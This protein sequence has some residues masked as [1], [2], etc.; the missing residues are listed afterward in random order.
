[1][2]SN[3]YLSLFPALLIC[4]AAPTVVLAQG[5]AAGVSPGRFELSAKPG[6][7]IRET[8]A[9]SNP[10]QT[11]A[12]Y[13]LK[14]AD[15]Q[16][17]DASSVEYIEDS[18]TEGSCRPWVRLERKTVAVA[19][20]GRKNYRFEV[21][22]PEDAAP[23]LCRFA[24]L[25]EPAEAYYAKVGDGSVSIPVVGRYAVIT[26]VTIGD[27]AADIQYLGLSTADTN[28]LR[29]PAITL[30]N[31]GTAHDRAFGQI[32]ATDATGTRYSLI[33]SNFPILPGR[34][35]TLP[36]MVE[37]LTS[38]PSPITADHPLQYPIELRGRIE[39]GGETIQIDEALP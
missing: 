26:Y 17:N 28:G 30:R 16:L 2:S 25:I 27:A 29:M 21:H 11:E 9:I 39:V 7:V 37:Q 23:G 38:G 4:M 8:V 22:V 12:R 10:G 20:H 1:M 6:D 14:T 34:S 24:I 18:L 31:T 32:T 35:E 33:P 15:W 13:L 3:R 5:F 19:S 36:L